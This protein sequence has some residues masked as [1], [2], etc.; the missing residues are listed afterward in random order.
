MTGKAA[1]ALDRLRENIRLAYRG[2]RQAVDLVLT[3]LFS[4]GHVLI[5]D[6]PG[7]G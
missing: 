1:P 4:R 7:V 2:S 5:E 6:V 3:A